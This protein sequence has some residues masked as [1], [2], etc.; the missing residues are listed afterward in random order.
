MTIADDA[1][2]VNHPEDALA[3]TTLTQAITSCGA[4]HLF[5]R[6]PATGD[7]LLTEVG[8]RGYNNHRGVGLLE[9]LEGG[10]ENRLELH[11]VE[12]F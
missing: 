6:E 3:T 8:V 4:S 2:T 11:L 5:S 10:R 9:V 12:S 7:C 1:L